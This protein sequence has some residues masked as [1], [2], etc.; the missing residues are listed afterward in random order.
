LLLLYRPPNWKA[1]IFQFAFW[2]LGTLIILGW[3]GVVSDTGFD[4]S[5]A[6]GLLVLFLM[7]LLVRSS[8]RSFDISKGRVH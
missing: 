6:Y 7:L 1:F 8:A 2:A 5:A 4:T 3:I